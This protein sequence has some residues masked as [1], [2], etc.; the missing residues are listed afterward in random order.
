MIPMYNIDEK[1][2]DFTE[3]I[4]RNP[5]VKELYIERAKLY[6]A[7]GQYKKAAEDFKRAVPDYYPFIN[8]KEVC[9]KNYLIKEAEYF[10][11]KEINKNKNNIDAYMQRLHFYMRTKQI[12]KAILDCKTILKLSPN[13]E[14]ISA[15]YEILNRWD[16]PLQMRKENWI[17]R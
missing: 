5:N 6:D 7:K 8:I 9:E 13:N 3:V 1:I 11:T 4:K 16:T 15:L 14:T 12:E 17:I 2:K 10:Y